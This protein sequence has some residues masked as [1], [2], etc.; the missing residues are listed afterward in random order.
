MTTKLD[1]ELDGLD[2][3]QAGDK[4]RD[5]GIK[6]IQDGY[7]ITLSDAECDLVGI[8]VLYGLIM[9]S[10][11]DRYGPFD[12]GAF[13]ANSIV[14]DYTVETIRRAIAENHGLD[15]RRDWR[16]EVE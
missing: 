10:L 16:G 1:R 13:E 8:P 3:V 4:A 15:Y 2:F 11:D 5:H 9:D 12:K 7:G 14:L 6:A